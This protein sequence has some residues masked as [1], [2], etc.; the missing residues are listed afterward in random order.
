MATT[1]TQWPFLKL[2]KK[3]TKKQSAKDLVPKVAIEGITQSD[4]TT[5]EVDA[6]KAL[7]GDDDL[8]VEVAKGEEATSVSELIEEQEEE[9]TAGNGHE[10]DA[11]LIALAGAAVE[12][13]IHL[14]T[15]PA[16][17]AAANRVPSSDEINLKI[18]LNVPLWGQF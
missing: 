16:V 9:A 5:T 17:V 2:L 6:A 11:V 14:E 4:E 1:P 3:L 13:A 12:N 15:V 7:T 8:V 10:A 18:C